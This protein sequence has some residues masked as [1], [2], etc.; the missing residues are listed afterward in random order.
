MDVSYSSAQSIH[1]TTGRTAKR[2]NRDTGMAAPP[3]RLDDLGYD[4]E[5]ERD[6]FRT[7]YCLPDGVALKILDLA[8]GG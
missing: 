6:G 8:E 5:P 3:I 1:R 2:W 7:H 4:W